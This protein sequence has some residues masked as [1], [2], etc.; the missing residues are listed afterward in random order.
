MSKGNVHLLVALSLVSATTFAAKERVIRIQNT[1]RVGYDDNVYLDD[2]NVGSGFVTDIINIS[3][4]LTFS[5]RSD[6]LLYWQPEFRYRMDADPEMVTYQDLYARF[7]HAISQRTF[8]K[9]SD[10]FRYQQKDGQTGA[11]V[12]V[13]RANQ[14]YFE[15]DLLGALDFTLSPK[16]QINVGAGYEFRVWDD[17]KYG[18]GTKGNNYDQFKAN[19]SYIRELK[20]NTTQ[21][22]L[23]INYVDHAYDGD[24]GGFN[25][26]T[27]FA[28]VDQNFNAHVL[29]NAR[30]GYSFSNVD[31]GSATEDN[32]TS[33]PY[34]QA[35]MEVN[36]TARTSFTGSLGYSLYQ[37]DN[38][39]YNA[40]DRFSLGLGIRHD[41]TGK[42][43]LSS[44][45][46]YIYS[47]YDADYVTAGKAA[48]D[49]Q[50]GYF[51]FNLRGSY[52]IN[53]NNF[54]DAG[55]QYSNRASDSSSLNEYDRNVVD[56]GWRLR[57]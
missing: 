51:I 52:Q 6:M 48:E 28:G 18:K 3:G 11:G 50:D 19:G 55:Y 54:V 42:V 53:R 13:D 16:G 35:G 20:P 37:S 29:G 21:G 5:S 38:S 26:T 34:L 12:G 22:L 9:I 2:G 43:S 8:L 44:S 30:L 56:I 41:L 14:N 32:N 40:Q 27:I 1:V 57:L 47:L 4:K 17:E 23:G 24:R 10:R 33:S 46:T 45:I 49:A 25:S 36:P 7:N 31:G 39:V 15:N